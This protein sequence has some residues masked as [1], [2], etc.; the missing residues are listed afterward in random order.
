VVLHRNA[1]PAAVAK[2]IAE[3]AQLP[4]AAAR[5]AGQK[6]R[7]TAER[8]LLGG[9]SEIDGVRHVELV[10]PARLSS[11]VARTILR[12]A[13][14]APSTSGTPATGAGEVVAIAD[15][16]FDKG[17][18]SDAHPAFKGRVKKLHALGRPH[19]TDD[20]HG[21]GTH[22]AG[23]VLGDAVSQSEGLVRGTAPGAHLVL[24]SLLD[25][26]GRL[27]GL[28][29]NLTEL[30]A[31][32]YK[33]DGARVHV[34]S[35]GGTGNGGAY[36]QQA[37]ELDSFVYE[38]R[39]L[40]VCCS[41]G[42]EG[43]DAAA[44]GH[45]DAGSI[46]PPGTA[47]NC[48]TVGAS[49]NDRSTQALTYGKGW[50]DDFPVKPFALDK[51]ADNPQGIAAFSGRGPTRDQRIKP[52]LVAPGTCIMS[53]RS[54]ATRSEGWQL[55][56]D[57]LYMYGGGTSTATGRSLHPRNSSRSP[58]CGPILR[59]TGCKATSISSSRAGRSNATATW[60]RVRRTSIAATTSSRS[61]GTARRRS[62]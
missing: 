51:V 16:G 32:P 53:A 4:V 25:P 30:L 26:Q 49:E 14:A 55:S 42:N 1:K 12:V 23:C 56:K 33:H 54:R 3:A 20:P 47:K 60:P 29:V 50:P 31:Q 18:T 43:R 61:C 15:T 10:L 34:M 37:F 17:S 22:V 13:D 48:L 21:H 52:D 45:I 9:I 27:G 8:R 7:L 6:V 41:A 2:E 46:T 5:I 19:H 44:A 62:R 57:P 40:L 24:Q 28:P 35:W 38:N 39:D 36:D 11:N 58:W 59:E